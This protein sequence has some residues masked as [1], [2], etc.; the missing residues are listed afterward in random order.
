MVQLGVDHAIELGASCKTLLK[1]GHAIAG[2]RTRL[3]PWGLACVLDMPLCTR[4]QLGTLIP[5]SRGPSWHLLA[6]GSSRSLA[7]LSP[8]CPCGLARPLAALQGTPLLPQHR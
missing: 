4:T 7:L 6:F 5:H 3:H 2:A 8:A 1:L